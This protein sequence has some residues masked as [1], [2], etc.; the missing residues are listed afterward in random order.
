LIVGIFEGKKEENWKDETW[1]V[2]KAFLE[3]NYNFIWP[4]EIPFNT[5]TFR[6]ILY[7]ILGKVLPASQFPGQESIY[8]RKKQQLW[9]KWLN[10]IS[11]LVIKT[12]TNEEL[13]VNIG[14]IGL[15][16]PR[17]YQR[18]IQAML[19]S[20]ERKFMFKKVKLKENEKHVESL[21]VKNFFGKEIDS[22]Q[23]NLKEYL[24]V[25]EDLFELKRPNRLLAQVAQ[26]AA[27]VTAKSENEFNDSVSR[28]Q[29]FIARVQN[30][31]IVGEKVETD[32]DK[33]NAFLQSIQTIKTGLKS[34]N[35]KI[36][37]MS[38]IFIGETRFTLNLTPK[39]SDI[40][41]SV[42]IQ[43]IRSNLMKSLHQI[44]YQFGMNQAN[45]PKSAFEQFLFIS[46]SI[47]GDIIPQMEIDQHYWIPISS[48][49]EFYLNDELQGEVRPGTILGGKNWQSISVPDEEVSTKTYTIKTPKVLP[50]SPNYEFI[51]FTIPR[52]VV[53]WNREAKA[54]ERSFEEVTLPLAQ[55][56]IGMLTRQISLKHKECKSLFKKYS[57]VVEVLET[58]GKIRE[59]ESSQYLIPEKIQKKINIKLN[60]SVGISFPFKENLS[61]EKLSKHLYITILK[62]TNRFHKNLSVEE[63]N[64]KAYTLWRF[65]QSEIIQLIPH[66]PFVKPSP[67]QILNSNMNRRIKNIFENHDLTLSTEGET[68]TLISEIDLITIFSQNPGYDDGQKLAIIA[69]IM[70][71]LEVENYLILTSVL[72][73][74]KQ[75][76]A[77]ENS[78]LDVNFDKLQSEFIL[79]S[80]IKLQNL[81]NEHFEKEL[82]IS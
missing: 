10:K 46:E 20:I 4:A 74:S 81:L 69:K 54:F 53:A 61:S 31:S 78:N 50:G 1:I 60:N 80:I 29:Q 71:I 6:D 5:G 41:K 44:V 12:L 39:I 14:G 48:S 72:T 16:D 28:M 42:S 55:W 68:H 75:L 52:D 2:L 15:F 62:Q 38:K 19:S 56:L 17:N 45:I 33:L 3:K 36:V 11:S 67:P 59:F 30:L 25:F 22:N 40:T 66:K 64:N 79:D 13:P 21:K 77:I 8:K 63:Q 9:I 49:A 37:G 57:K 27:R 82:D 73:Y 34:Y 65:V 26:Q 18:R 58:E 32:T 51:Y 47:S 24:Q 76:S 7:K 35:K 23:F 70:K 43:Q